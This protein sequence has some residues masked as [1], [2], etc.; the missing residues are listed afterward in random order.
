MLPVNFPPPADSVV[1]VSAKDLGRPKRVWRQAMP[2]GCLYWHR[3][4]STF[5]D[6]PKNLVKLPY[7]RRPPQ[8]PT[9]IA[10]RSHVRLIYWKVDGNHMRD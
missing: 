2:E 4:Y 5:V 9:A 6:S 10:F 7:Q 3:G 1:H 8:I